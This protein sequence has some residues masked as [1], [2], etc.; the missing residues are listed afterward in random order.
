MGGGTGTTPTSTLVISHTGSAGTSG[1]QLPALTGVAAAP[2]AGTVLNIATTAL[3]GSPTNGYGLQVAAPSG[4]TNNYAATF[5]GGNVGIG[6][7]APNSTLQ[8]NGSFAKALVNK[9]TTYT[10]TASD[11]IITC[12]GTSGAFNVTLPTAASITGREYTIKKT[13][14]SANACTVATT[15]SQTI[16]ANTTY[17]LATQWKYVTVV[18]NGSNWLVI[19]NN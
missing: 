5:S 10:A 6:T 15:S 9:T 4:A 18:S 11:S 3:A 13:D 16:D 2:V 8:V 7:T 19:A 1:V 12:D 14:S 17:S